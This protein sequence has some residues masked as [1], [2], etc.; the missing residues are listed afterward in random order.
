MSKK[1]GPDKAG[2]AKLNYQSEEQ[3]AAVAQDNVEAPQPFYLTRLDHRNKNTTRRL[4]EM[5]AEEE[6]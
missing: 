6:V 2:A 3:A 1:P 5:D 4:D